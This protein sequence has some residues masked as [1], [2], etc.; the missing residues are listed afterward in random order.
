MGQGQDRWRLPKLQE[1]A[2]QSSVFH[3]PASEERGGH[4][5]LPAAGHR[6]PG[7]LDRFL[8]HTD[9]GYARAYDL[10]AISVSA[11]VSVVSVPPNQD[12]GVVNNARKEDIVQKS[13]F[14]KDEEGAR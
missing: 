11:N 1:L 2:Q 10:R 5:S 12:A 3:A 13:I 7:Q 8:H 9:Q 14:R 6:E 4:H